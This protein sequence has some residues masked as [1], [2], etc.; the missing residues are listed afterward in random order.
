MIFS[1]KYFNKVER[2]LLYASMLWYLSDGLLGPF[3]AI[4]SEKIGG[5]ILDISWAL[6]AYYLVAGFLYIFVGKI[7][8]K[9]KNERQVMVWGYALNAL[10]TFLYIFV[11]TPNQLLLLQVGFGITAAMATP[12][13]NKIFAENESKRNGGLLWGLSDGTANIVMGIGVILGGLI[14][15]FWS[16]EVLFFIM[17]LIQVWATFEQAKILRIRSAAKP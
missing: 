14:I 10:I 13:W 1:K 6:A 7:I 2:N 3:F 5:D 12:T 15:N 16:F 8:D 17:G 11:S 9:Y 4:Y